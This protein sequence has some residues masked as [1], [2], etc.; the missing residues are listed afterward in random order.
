M[1]FRS[2][3]TELSYEEMRKVEQGEEFLKSFGL[4]N[5]RLRIHQE[6]ARIEVDPGE[7]PVLLQ[8]R[9]NVISYMKELGY[10]YVTLDLE[11]FRSGSMDVGMK[12]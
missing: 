1:L 2:Y 7:F 8:N 5:V 9:E 12:S 6:V 10:S 3:G 4:Y 11:G